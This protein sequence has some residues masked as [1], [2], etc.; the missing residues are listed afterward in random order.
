[1]NYFEDYITDKM[2]N[3]EIIIEATS[4]INLDSTQN[5]EVKKVIDKIYDDKVRG[6]QEKLLELKDFDNLMKS[7]SP[8]DFGK[9][10]FDD[11]ALSGGLNENQKANLQSLISQS[12][13]QNDLEKK[14]INNS[15]NKLV[16]PSKV[17]HG[18]K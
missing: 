11:K 1:M 3:A 9:L 15:I 2:R 5:V 14:E 16:A 6:P 8:K 12:A 7:M 13:T 18:S 10:M 17:T 4:G